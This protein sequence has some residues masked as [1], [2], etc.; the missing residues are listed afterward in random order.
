MKH[1]TPTLQAA[2]K[3]NRGLK[4]GPTSAPTNT[5]PGNPTDPTTEPAGKSPQL[6]RQKNKTMTGGTE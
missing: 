1:E 3:Q 2:V 4:S 6:R 5:N